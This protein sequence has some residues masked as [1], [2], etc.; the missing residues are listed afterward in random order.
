MAEEDIISTL[1]D[2][3]LCHILSFLETKHAVATTI[4]STR[5]KHL[6]LSVPVLYF[7]TTVT[8]QNA[9]INFNDFVYSVLLSRDPSFPIKTFYFDFTYQ[10]DQILYPRSSMDTIIKWVKFVTQRG[11]EYIDLRVVLDQTMSCIDLPITILTCSTLVVL[12]LTG[13]YVEETVLF[14]LLL[15]H[16]LKPF[17]W[18][19]FGSLNFEIL[20]CS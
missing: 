1:P 10:D 7:N 3:I 20:S 5:W 2:A 12:K 15:F 19:I 16:L 18:T 13:F 8:N 6:W 14:L 11:V 9:Y 17:T 4:L